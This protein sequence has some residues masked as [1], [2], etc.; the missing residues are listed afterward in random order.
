[1]AYNAEILYEHT[2]GCY[3]DSDDSQPAPL[4]LFDL[5]L[6]VTNMFRV[7]EHEPP[8]GR[9][10]DGRRSHVDDF[11]AQG[12]NNADKQFFKGLLALSCQFD[13]GNVWN[14]PLLNEM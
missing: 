5:N 14:L 7:K 9:P 12:Q 8:D 1:M 13:L 3:S 6:C 11:L 10:P 4:E 2:N